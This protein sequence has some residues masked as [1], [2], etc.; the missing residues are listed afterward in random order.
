[1]SSE[2]DKKRESNGH[3]E[4]TPSPKRQKNKESSADINCLVL[5]IEGTTTPIAFVA[6]VLFPYIRT[7]LESHMNTNWGNEELMADIAALRA[8]AEE[9]TKNGATVRMIPSEAAE[10]SEI[11]M[12][13]MTNVFQQMDADRK[14]TALK[15]LQGHIWQTG[16]SNGELKGQ[17]WEDVF[18]AF[19]KW[20]DASV[21]VFIY[22][23]G[24]VEA[25]KL[26]FGF[27]SHGDL[28]PY[29]SGHFDTT[30]GSK[31]ESP[32]Y[33]S[34]VQTIAKTHP[35]VTIGSALFV[36]DNILEADAAK[37]V[38][39]N[40]VLAVRPGN[41]PLPADHPYLTAPAFDRLFE[42]FNFA[43]PQ[44]AVVIN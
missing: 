4:E 19:K 3:L 8:L 11:I 21:P 44:I 32:S 14:T 24:S 30:I 40:A 41:K 42:S 12:A 1:M 26:I 31:I 37:A 18:A 39:M 7:S 10:K 35:T 29:L 38:G 28:L 34:I 9:D 2:N 22:S 27:S 36:T 17:V 5:D 33:T 13:V 25:Q 6:D 16:Y 20:K 15:A 23:S 43:A